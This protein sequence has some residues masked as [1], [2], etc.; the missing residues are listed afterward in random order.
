MTPID[1]TVRDIKRPRITVNQALT[2]MVSTDQTIQ[3][4]TG[5]QP[6]PFRSP[7]RPVS[8]DVLAGVEG[9]RRRRAEHIAQS[10]RLVLVTDQVARLLR[11][12]R[13]KHPAAGGQRPGPAGQLRAD[14]RAVGLVPQPLGPLLQS[15]TDGHHYRYT[16]QCNVSRRNSETT[17]RQMRDCIRYAHVSTAEAYKADKSSLRH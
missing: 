10:C 12:R 13:V 2:L 4:E 11:D 8:H 6:S 3:R 15:G 14:P 1:D 16:A 9:V 5:P 7:E 17:I